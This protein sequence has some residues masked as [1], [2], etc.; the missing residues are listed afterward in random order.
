MPIF[1]RQLFVVASKPVNMTFEIFP[2]NFDSTTSPD[3]MQSQTEALYWFSTIASF[4]NHSFA[5][6]R[7]ENTKSCFQL[8]VNSSI[9][10]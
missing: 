9:P 5:R 6:V 7:N 8:I 4:F 3:V 1:R 2:A 10:Y